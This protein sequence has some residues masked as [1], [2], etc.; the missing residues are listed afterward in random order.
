[1]EGE[2]A[3]NAL[4]DRFAP[5]ELALEPDFELE[6]MPLPYMYGPVALP[7]RVRPGSASH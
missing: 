1:M 2:E 4:L 3:L 5:G 7:V 6:L